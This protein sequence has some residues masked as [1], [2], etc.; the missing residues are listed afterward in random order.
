MG[1]VEATVII[2]SFERPERLRACLASLLDDPDDAF[3]VLVVDDGSRA[4]LA[5]ICAEFGARVRCLRQANQ[6][7]AAARNRGAEHARGG[8]LAFTDDDCQPHPGWVRELRRA[9]GGDDG[10]LVG[11][12]VQ[13]GLPKIPF[14][15]ASQALCD[16]L[17]DY[18]EASEG[19]A[20]FFTSNNVG[21]SKAGFLRAGGFDE[22]FPLA[23]AEDRDFGLRWRGSGGR[24]VFAPDAVVTHGH[25]MG[26]GGYW[27]QHR[28]YGRGARQLHLRMDARGDPRPR[29]EPLSF[30]RELVARPV[31]RRGLGGLPQSALLA[32]SQLAMVR[33]YA[34]EVARERGRS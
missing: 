13:N 18:F 7:P 8:F 15:S 16:Y 23:A 32:L 30:Y 17:Y 10:V 27:R 9:H 31:R 28:N 6:G 3:E 4:P 14:S 34:R 22:S 25:E 20:D 11:G 24:L 26:L 1:E 19:R 2:P 5:P 33:G 29:R 21:A 12:R